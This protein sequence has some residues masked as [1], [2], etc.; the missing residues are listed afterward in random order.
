MR[1]ARVT[2]SSA[3]TTHSI[4]DPSQHTL[5][6]F[7][8]CPRCHGSLDVAGT[9]VTCPAGHAFPNNDGY[10]D[11][12]VG[13]VLDA[14]WHAVAPA[15]QHLV[16]A[17][18]IAHRLD[19]YLLP[20]LRGYLGDDIRVLDDGTGYGHTVDGLVR[21]GVDA[22]GIDPGCR[23][24]QWE[25]LGLRGRLFSANG[26]A[27]PFQDASFDAVISSGVLE[28]VAEHLPQGERDGPCAE[29]VH[30][31]LRVL[32]PGGRALLAAPN[33]IHPFDYWHTYGKFLRVQ[34]PREKWMPTPSAIRTWVRSSPVPGTVRFLSPRG[35]LAFQRIRY[36]AC[37]RALSAG[38]RGLF[39]LMDWFPPL[40]ASPV[41]PWL[42]AELT[43]AI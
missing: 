12:M 20:Y 29:Y 24:D 21:R 19:N 5:P 42:V 2:R 26:R 27:L 7:L 37:G 34:I 1:L 28:H 18:G 15:D 31:V 17:L 4:V 22:Y 10:V 38:M 39:R 13:A 43:H 25:T 8:A 23:R 9:C 32:K 40:A 35:Y 33:G 16:E 30:E 11:F 41:N 36:H 14:E 3:C 6:S